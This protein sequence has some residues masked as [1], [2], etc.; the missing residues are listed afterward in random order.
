MSPVCMYGHMFVFYVC[1]YDF[2]EIVHS[3][4]FLLMNFLRWLLVKFSL[5]L[6]TCIKV[7][8]DCLSQNVNNL[9]FVTEIF[10]THFELCLMHT[11]LFQIKMQMK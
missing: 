5:S 7:C 1:L 3:H 2:D 6:N 8:K 11:V 9:N 10:Y 4:R